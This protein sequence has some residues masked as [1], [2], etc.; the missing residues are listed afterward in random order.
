[1]RTECNFSLHTQKEQLDEMHQVLRKSQLGKCLQDHAPTYCTPELSFRCGSILQESDSE[2][3]DDSCI[4]V[5]VCS[6]GTNPY[7]HALAHRL[8]H[9]NRNVDESSFIQNADSPA[10]H[11]QGITYVYM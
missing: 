2:D 4:T 10:T 9:T 5:W 3:M 7:L 8:V 6:K 11:E 1:M